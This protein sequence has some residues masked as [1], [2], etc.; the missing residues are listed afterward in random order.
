LRLWPCW[1]RSTPAPSGPWRARLPLASI[2]LPVSRGCFSVWSGASQQQIHLA[3]SSCRVKPGPWLR[4]AARATDLPR[5]GAAA[6]RR[7][8]SVCPNV[9]VAAVGS[10]HR[11]GGP[12]CGASSGHLQRDEVCGLHSDCGMPWSRPSNPRE[13]ATRSGKA[14][15]NQSAISTGE[16][17]ACF[18]LWACWLV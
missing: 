11:L 15:Y 5:N 10:L 16:S 4:P 13:S 1:C 9:A 12:G 6:V 17:C 14:V 3:G 2:E 8:V 18:G 7:Q